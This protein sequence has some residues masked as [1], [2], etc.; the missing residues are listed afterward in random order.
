MPVPHCLAFVVKWPFAARACTIAP[1]NCGMAGI[2]IC[3]RRE[4]ASPYAGRLYDHLTARFGAQRVFMDIDTIRPGD[5]F[6]QVIGERVA[7][8]EALIAVI[9]RRWL[10]S[11]DSH[12][13]RR[14]DDPNDYVRIEIASA[15]SRK[16][17]VIPALVDGAQMPAAHELPPDLA[18]LSR[19]NA[20]EITNTLFRQSVD[21][22]IGVLEQA[23]RPSPLSFHR[24]FKGKGA[25]QRGQ[26]RPAI[27]DQPKPV[28]ATARGA[29]LQPAKPILTA[30]GAFVLIQI[31]LFAAVIP[32]PGNLIVATILQCLALFAVMITP[33][34]GS[35]FDRGSAAKLSGCWL[36]AILF[37]AIAGSQAV[38][39]TYTSYGNRLIAMGAIGVVL[40]AVAG[41]VFG[42]LA[43]LVLP[44]IPWRSVWVLARTWGLARLVVWIASLLTP[45]LQAPAL[46]WFLLE[47]LLGGS[48][49]WLV[50][51]RR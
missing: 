10:S 5:D 30:A 40:E 20:I 44:A 48:V 9:G 43:R 26:A 39:P 22:L 25:G 50:H 45:T 34:L 23:L 1:S 16:V 2:F 31:L 29:G 42:S 21:Q 4:D 19:R 27:H 11:V 24:I 13:R 49:L 28:P 6:V 51:Q 8:C 7:G 33:A 47:A 14:L 18:A 15:L 17:R 32:Y 41:A 37:T 46:A 3:Y 36:A 38:S 12:G 35:G